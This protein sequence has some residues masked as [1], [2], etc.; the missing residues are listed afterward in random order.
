ML[1]EPML[2]LDT[3]GQCYQLNPRFHSN[4][5]LQKETADKRKFE[6]REIVGFSECQQRSCILGDWN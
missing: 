1:N 5:C 2:D 4:V 6:W 3:Y